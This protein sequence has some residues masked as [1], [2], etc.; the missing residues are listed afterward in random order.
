MPLAPSA[1]QPLLRLALVPGVGPGRM[2]A[3]VRYFGS[4]ERVLSAAA[5]AVAALPGFGAELV[6]RIQRARGAEAEARLER[7]LEAMQ[8]VGAVALS[9]ADLEYPDAFRRLPDPPFL[10]FASGSLTLLAQPALAI[11]GT[12]QPT[13]YGR[14]VAA[15]LSR[16]LVGAGYGIVSGM[17]RGIDAVAHAAALDAGGATVGVLGHGIEQVYP[18]ENRR[19]FERVRAEGLLLSEFPPGEQP[20]AGNFPRRNRLIAALG[21]AVI[22]VEMSRKSGAQ[23]TVT[24]AL[25]QGRDVFAV[26]GPITSPAS[27]GT[28]QLIQDGARLITSAADVLD[29]LRGVARARDVAVPA[30]GRPAPR[31][32]ELPLT[33]D[34]PADLAPEE[35]RVYG[36]LALEPRHVDELAAAAELPTGTVLAALLGL[37]LRGLVEALPGTQFRLVR[38]PWGG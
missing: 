15:A 24:F 34:A 23:H 21:E 1:L 36:A 16:E 4:A 8:R 5:P 14:G 19:L 25:E 7:A 17:A 9:P 11:V 20:V 30:A 29:E 3:L 31:A 6:R 37:E 13:A 27:E 28:N 26:P 33:A 32:P 12:R 18:A 10:L 38:S 2:A 22:V 35:A